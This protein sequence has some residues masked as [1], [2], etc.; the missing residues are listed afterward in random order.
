VL[1]GKVELTLVIQ[2]VVEVTFKEGGGPWWVGR[3]DLTRSL[4]RPATSIRCRVIVS[5]VAFEVVYNCDL[6]VDQLV[7]IGHE[8]AMESAPASWIFSKSLRLVTPFL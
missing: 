1:G 4:A 2:H 3:V 8:A 7:K 5:F 6:G